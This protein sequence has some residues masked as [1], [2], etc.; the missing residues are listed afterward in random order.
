MHPDNIITRPQEMRQR[1]LEARKLGKSIGFVPTL[2]NL[3]EGHAKLMRALRPEC[4]ILVSSIFINPTQF[5]EH[6]DLDTYPRS[7]VED[8]NLCRVEKNDLVFLP[9]A[10]DIYAGGK[11]PLT[12]IDIPSMTGLLCGGTR[13]HF[14]PAVIT[15]VNLLFNIL[16]PHKAAFGKKD[17]QQLR[18]IRI[19]TKELHLPTQIVAVDTGRAPDG[20]ALSSRNRYLT[21]AERRIAPRLYGTLKDLSKDLNKDP[22]KDLSSQKQNDYRELEQDGMR[23][24]RQHGFKPEYVQV[25]RTEDLLPAVGPADKP[26]ILAAA[27]LGKA[28]LIDNVPMAENSSESNHRGTAGK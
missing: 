5:A 19:M 8:L 12:L 20:L 10:E 16:L 28:R 18:L 14:F 11:K 21:A 25:C 1:S 24:L 7:T 26:V 9:K 23:R 6:E 13:P 3:H 27:W 22:G 15:I 4:D 17:F 2:G